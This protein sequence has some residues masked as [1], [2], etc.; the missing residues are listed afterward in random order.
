MQRLEANIIE[1]IAEEKDPILTW[2]HPKVTVKNI[3]GMKV[4]GI[5]LLSTAVDSFVDIS[6]T[7]FKELQSTLVREPGTIGI[8]FGKD[9]ECTLEQMIKRKHVCQKRAYRIPLGKLMPFTQHMIAYASGIRDD[10]PNESDMEEINN[11]ATTISD[12]GCES[13]DTLENELRIKLEASKNSQV[14][15]YRENTT[16][17]TESEEELDFSFTEKLTPNTKARYNNLTPRKRKTFAWAIEVAQKIIKRP[18]I[19]HNTTDV[20]TSQDKI[21][22]STPIATGDQNV[23]EQGN[24][25]PAR[26]ESHTRKRLFAEGAIGVLPRSSTR[27][28]NKSVGT[29]AGTSGLSCPPNSGKIK[30][31]KW[32]SCKEERDKESEDM[33]LIC[34]TTNKKNL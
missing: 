6:H 28:D 24:E 5:A 7:E 20:R 21:P 4:P 9:R 14:M 2:L 11:P 1:K 25:M 3:E 29:I 12:E 23:C 27:S 22:D 19:D 13:L 17:P 10:A 33:M 16:E 18:E 15:Q 34:E 31:Y 30:V 26:G 32:C 8:Y